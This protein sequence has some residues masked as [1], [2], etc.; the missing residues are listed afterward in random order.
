M[1]LILGEPGPGLIVKPG[2]YPDDSL[3]NT[4]DTVSLKSPKCLVTNLTF[5]TSQSVVSDKAL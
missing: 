1:K 3:S 4:T 5:K 2:E